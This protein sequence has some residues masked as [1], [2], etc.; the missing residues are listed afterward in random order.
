M[1]Y[2][3]LANGKKVEWDEFSKWSYKK[4]HTSLFPSNKGKVFSDEV[5]KRMSEGILKHRRNG[6]FKAPHGGEHAMAR[7]VQ[8]PAGVFETLKA[9]GEHYGVNGRY[10]RNWIRDGKVGFDFLSPP[11]NR[12]STAAKSSRN[13]K[14]VATPNGV[15]KSIS[16]C[17][18]FYQL[19]RAEIMNRVKSSEFPEY[20]LL[21]TKEN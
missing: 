17:M 12:K 5:R 9:A 18:D 13:A 20:Y 6:I 10:I 11:L 4:Q 3:T 8:T 16:A 2:V 14:K 21:G 1:E 7:R 15:F 19:S